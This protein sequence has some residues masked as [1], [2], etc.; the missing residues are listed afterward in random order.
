[1]T[2]ALALSHANG[3]FISEWEKISRLQRRT[4]RLFCPPRCFWWL[5]WSLS[6][7]DI[8]RTF[9]FYQRWGERHSSVT[10][11]LICKMTFAE[12]EQNPAQVQ[13]IPICPPKRNPGS[14]E[15]GIS[16]CSTK[17]YALESTVFT[18]DPPVFYSNTHVHHIKFFSSGSCCPGTKQAGF[19][20]SGGTKARIQMKKNKQIKNLHRKILS[21]ANGTMVICIA[22]IMVFSFVM[23]EWR[24]FFDEKD[25]G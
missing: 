14:S 15:M 25:V 10:Y 6:N 16:R 20:P 9:C 12:P 24:R 7:T 19:K 17:S 1:M 4:R 13:K 11:L 5:D 23:I 8:E 21:R 18:S 2:W 3:D 22:N